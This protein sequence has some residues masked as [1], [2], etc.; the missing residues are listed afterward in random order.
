[1]YRCEATSVEGFVQQLAVSYLAHGYWFYVTGHVPDRK[2]PHAVDRKLIEHYGI[3]HSKWERARRKR[4]GAANVQYLRFERFFVLL[5]THGAHPF[6]DEEGN[7]VHDARRVPIRFHGYALSHHGGHP[8]VR[9]EQAEYNRLKAYFLDVATH[10][11]ADQL[12]AEL[13]RLPFEPYA[14]VRRQLLA[15]LRAVN[16]AR[17]TAAMESVASTCFRFRRQICRPFEVSTPTAAGLAR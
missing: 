5:A 17:G 1:M 6:F 7:V 2:D 15:V 10:R 3:D 13:G 4:A 8:H 11:S 16:R 14:P 12:A 9:I